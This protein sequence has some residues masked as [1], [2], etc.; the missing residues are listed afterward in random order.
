MLPASRSANLDSFAPKL[1]ILDFLA[2]IRL[3]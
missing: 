1:D 3:I 2:L